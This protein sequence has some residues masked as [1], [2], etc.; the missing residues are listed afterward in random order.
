M[1]DEQLKIELLNQ[2]KLEAEFRNNEKNVQKRLMSLAIS[3]KSLAVSL[4]MS[5]HFVTF[6]DAGDA[7]SQGCYAWE[8]LKSSHPD[9]R[10]QKL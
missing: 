10:K 6:C 2:W 3:F 4:M 1:R 9:K 7:H 8:Q 5:Q